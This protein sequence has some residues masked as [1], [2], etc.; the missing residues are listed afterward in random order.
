M[1][2]S[3]KR[4]RTVGGDR[5]D[6]DD[7]DDPTHGLRQIL[8]VANLPMDFDGE[9]VDGTQYLF[10]VRRDARRLPDIK[11]VDN[12]YVLSPPWPAR[13]ADQLLANGSTKHVEA[14]S[15]LP[16]EEWRSEFER[17]FRNLRGNI[18]QPTG[19]PRQVGPLRKMIPD[20][21]NRDAWWAFLEGAPESVWD[22]SRSIKHG[23]QRRGEGHGA[24][25]WSPSGTPPD[26]DTPRKPRELLPTQLFQIDHRFS[27]HLVMYFTYWFNLYLKSLDSDANDND[28]N[29]AP[30]YIPTDIHMRWI[31]ALLTRIDL[32]CSADDMS[33]LR[34]LA[35]AC[36]ALIAV[37]RRGKAGSP[38]LSASTHDEGGI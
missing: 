31:F 7:D 3:K 22:P 1:A 12:P 5:H 29:T 30:T 38:S 14:F 19:H 10:T 21:K 37:I 36:I 23:K 26:D 25:Q 2:P 11:S 24:T 35:R 18:S 16:S 6:D 28:N 20:K 4:K 15:P 32:F 9:P 33:C 34:D 17:H 27:L 8:P 13:S